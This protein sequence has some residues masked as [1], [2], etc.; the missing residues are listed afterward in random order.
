MNQNSTRHSLLHTN[1]S[2]VIPLLITLLLVNLGLVAA[3]QQLPAST[4]AA[5]AALVMT[6]T[7]EEG[8]TAS[9][10]A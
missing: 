7:G 2:G 9:C 5:A 1:N 10:D 8:A 6:V 3:N 4:V